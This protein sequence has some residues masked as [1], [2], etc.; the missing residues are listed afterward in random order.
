MGSYVTEANAR[1]GRPS[2]EG[3][4]VDYALVKHVDAT[5]QFEAFADVIE[6]AAH[7]APKTRDREEFSRR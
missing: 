4:H 5:G 7:E 1:T 2:G 3:L 6:A